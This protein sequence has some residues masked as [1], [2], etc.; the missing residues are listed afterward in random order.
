GVVRWSAV[1]VTDITDQPAKRRIARLAA[2]SGKPKDPKSIADCM[3][4]YCQRLDEVGEKSP[5]L[6]VLPEV[7]NA[8]QLRNDGS[9][10]SEPI[11]GY[12]TDRL[13]EKARKYRTYIV[14]SLV[15]EE[16]PR[17]Y[18]TAVVLDREGKIIGKYRKTHLTVGE[19]LLSGK[20]PGDSYPVFDTDFG[21]IGVQICFDNHYPEVARILAVKGAEIIAFPNMSD[22][23]EGGELWEPTVRVRAVDNHVH[24]VAAVNFGRSCIVSPRGELLSTT[25][26]ER[27]GIALAECDLDQSVRNYSDRSIGKRYL[28]VR[29]ADTFE[30]LLHHY[31]ESKGFEARAAQGA[32]D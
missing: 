19:G 14:A 9:N 21:R 7:I 18:N 17:L 8:D 2:I 3:D 16:G 10:P 12:S 26:K 11:P 25:G 6:V 22:S 23:R 5:D 27:G 28:Q 4:F 30:P 32:A 29:R 24:I 20:R 15:E 31:W 1:R 13:A